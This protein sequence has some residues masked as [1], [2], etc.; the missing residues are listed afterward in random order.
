MFEQPDR[1]YPA[2]QSSVTQCQQLTTA[3]VEKTQLGRAAC[4][5]MKSDAD[6]RSGQDPLTNPGKI[7]L[8]GTSEF[9]SSGHR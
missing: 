2:G 7:R 5:F 6:L 8:T 9:G 3:V 1:A 4:C